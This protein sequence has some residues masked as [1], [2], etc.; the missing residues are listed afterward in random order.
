MRHTAFLFALLLLITLSS[1]ADRDM[2]M[3]ERKSFIAEYAPHAVT[4][5]HRNNI[6]ASITLAQFVLE[7]EWG[8]GEL[9]MNANAPF[10]IKCSNWNGATY[11]KEDDD[12]DAQGRLISSCFRK[13]NRV[14]DAFPDRS[15][16]LKKKRYETLFELSRFDYKGWAYGLK[17]CGYATDI[18]YAHKLIRIIEEYGLFMYDYQQPGTQ[19]ASQGTKA[20]QPVITQTERPVIIA[21]VRQPQSSLVPVATNIPTYSALKPL[22]E[23][24]QHK[25]R[26]AYQMKPTRRSPSFGGFGFDKK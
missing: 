3:A 7:S 6:P 13:Y 4:E 5:M 20:N 16:F 9:F 25:K 11:Y 1:S 15:K 24:I 23:R 14:A 18:S 22:K 2:N 12:K 26:R 10:G 19:T 17:S 8:R 21:P